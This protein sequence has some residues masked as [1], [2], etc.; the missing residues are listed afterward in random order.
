MA[1]LLDR[2]L[3]ARVES[4]I[5]PF[6]E[7][8]LGCEEDVEERMSRLGIPE[9]VALEILMAKRSQMT[10][11]ATSVAAGSDR[12]DHSANLKAINGHIGALVAAID[13]NELITLTGVALATVNAA[14]GDGSGVS[15]SMTIV[16][17]NPRR[18]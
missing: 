6:P 18:G 14:R 8:G 11:S 7:S 1:D 15:E 17:D 9:V 13:S 2:A 4:W 10:L 12:S 3:R 16:A 5:G